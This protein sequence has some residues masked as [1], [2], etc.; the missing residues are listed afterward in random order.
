M[1]PRISIITLGVKSMP[2]SI[3]FYRDGLGFP[4]DAKDDW[5]WV[6]FRGKLGTRPS[7]LV[8]G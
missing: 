7:F 2:V 5:R 3:R 6:I 4:T 8:D 1:E